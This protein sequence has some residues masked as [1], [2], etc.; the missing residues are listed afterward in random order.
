[1]SAPILSRS[2]EYT[3]TSARPFSRT[4]ASWIPLMAYLGLAAVLAAPFQYIMAKDEVNFLTIAERYAQGDWRSAPNAYWY[5]LLSWLEAIPLWFHIKPASAAKVVSV[6]SGA[7]AYVALQRLLNVLG[8][9]EWRRVLFSAL[10]VPA[11]LYFTYFAAIADLLLVA[12]VIFYVAVT[13][14][15]PADGQKS[16]DAVWR[17]II[18]ALAYFCKAYGLYFVLAHVSVL[19]LYGVVGHKTSVQR[20]TVIAHFGIT[21][22]VMGIIIGPW[23]GMLHRKYGVTTLGIHGPYNY[24]IRSPDFPDAPPTT[25]FGLMRPPDTATVSIWEE[26]YYLNAQLTSWSPLDS[27]RAFVHQL[28]LMKKSAAVLLEALTHFTILWSAFISLALLLAFGPVPR[29]DSRLLG[30]ML[31]ATLLY[32]LGYMGIYCEERY[33]WPEYILIFSLMA[34]LIERLWTNKWTNK[35]FRHEWFKWVTLG[36]VSVSFLPWPIWQLYSRANQGRAIN[37]LGELLA[38]QGLSGKKIA[39]NGDYSASVCIAYRVKAKY[40]GQP[41]PEITELERDRTLLDNAI[42]YFLVWDGVEVHSSALSKI[43]EFRT[44]GR[45]LALYAVLK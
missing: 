17:G 30:L 4:L 1:M 5:P 3:S 6:L 39:S 41:K 24:A 26:P 13:M 15:S 32:P 20:R 9:A 36:V 19:T 34:F 43:R 7:L 42:D 11:L 12:I 25:V 8:V 29:Y 45:I 44:G 23:V 18:G 10:A 40:Y 21:L 16:L 33:L 31:F 37:D 28:H 38:S 35:W 27:R 2:T 22:V 14:K